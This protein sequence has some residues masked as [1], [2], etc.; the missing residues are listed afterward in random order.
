MQVRQRLHAAARTHAAH[1]IEQVPTT[2]VVLARDRRI[3]L[4]NPA[5]EAIFDDGALPRV[6][7]GGR[8][9][10][11]EPARLAALE[12]ALAACASCRFDH[13]V[14]LSVR[15]AGEPGGGIVARLV[16]P[17]RGDETR[18]V[19]IGFLAREGR[20][21]L[22][23]QAVMAALYRLTPG[24]AALVKALTDGTTMEAF[25]EVRRISLATA[26]TQLQSVFAKTGTRRQSDLMRLVYSI[27]R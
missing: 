6:A 3:L 12:Q 22:E 23:P 21:A 14:S 17:P 27:A 4:A 5:A 26:K 24:E 15:L 11:D 19:A 20:I 18:A 8:L 7:R 13:P 9:C 25:A 1:A 16:P 2:I 10:A